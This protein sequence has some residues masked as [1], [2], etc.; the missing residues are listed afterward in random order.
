M[1]TYKLGSPDINLDAGFGI[2]N[3]KNRYDIT[4]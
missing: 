3:L 2:V 1:D 4:V